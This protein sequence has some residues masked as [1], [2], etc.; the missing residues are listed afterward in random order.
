MTPNAYRRVSPIVPAVVVALAVVLRAQTPEAPSFEVASI[1]R[2]TSSDVG[3]FTDIAGE[4]F[5][6]R[7][8]TVREL[9]GWSYGGRY[10][11]REIVGGPDWI[12]VDRFA[13]IAQMGRPDAPVL[14]MVRSLLIERFSL[15]MHEEVR[16]RPVFHLVLARPNGRLGPGLV[17]STIDCQAAAK[18]PPGDGERCGWRSMS[19]RFMGKGV[20]IPLL[21]LQLS[22]PVQ[23]R[24]LDKTMLAGQFDIDLTWASDGPRAGAPVGPP[25]AVDGERVGSSI[26]T[27]LQEQLGLELE[28]AREAVPVVVIDSINRPTED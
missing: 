1:K 28:P 9:L 20:S 6:A 5:T 26:F 7:N 13:I 23:R 21:V 27:A 4:T 17:P 16:E 10:L 11:S 15:R 24:I 8:I 18:R 3:I 19:G 25:F 12:D 22:F 14:R 2:M